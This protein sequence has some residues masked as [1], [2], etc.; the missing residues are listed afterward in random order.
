VNTGSK[1]ISR[2][3]GTGSNVFVDAAV[4]A[5]VVTGGSPLD[6]D[7]DAGILGVIDHGAGQSHLSFFTYNAFGELA[8]SGSPITISVAERQ[9]CRHHG[10]ALTACQQQKRLAAGADVWNTGRRDG[11]GTLFLRAREAKPLGSDDGSSTATKVNVTP[12][13]T[14]SH[15]GQGAISADGLIHTGRPARLRPPFVL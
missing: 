7:A 11:L 13:R 4:A 9:R 1:T 3:V 8:A 12:I 6:L 14:A 10:R 15:D 2:L 5:T